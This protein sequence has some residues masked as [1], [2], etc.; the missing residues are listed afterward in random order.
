MKRRFPSRSRLCR[1][2]TLPILLILLHPI[3][4]HAQFGMNKLQ[5]GHHSW[6]HVSTRHFDLY[7]SEN[8]AVVGQY[9]AGHVEALYDSVSRILGFPLK[10]KV[11][12]ILYATPSEFQQTNII[13]YLLP[14][15]V[16]GFTEIFRNRVVIPF[17][18]SYADL[19]HVLEHEMTHAFMFDRQNT[20]GS[21]FSSASQQVPLWFGEGLAEFTS[22]GW[23]LG[24]EFYMLDAVLFGYVGNPA[25]E[26]LPGFLAYKGG[27]LFWYYLSQTFG[28]SFVRDWIAEMNK[29]SDPGKSFESLSHVSLREVGDIWLREI[30]SIY[31]PELRGRRYGKAV[32]RQLT[33]H[34][35]DG[36]NLN[37][38]PVLSPDGTK[39]AFFS[40]REPDL[41]IHV[42][43]VEKEKVS[44]SLSSA[45]RKRG[46]L[47]FYPYQSRLTWSPDGKRLAFVSKTG[48]R[49]VISMINSKNGRSAGTISPPGIQS[50]LSPDWSPDGERIV[51][52]GIKDGMSDIFV[53]DIGKKALTRLTEDIAVDQNPVYSPSGEW[54]AFESD[55]GKPGMTYDPK[56][57]FAALPE[58]GSFRDVYR[59]SSAGGSPIR[60]AGGPFDEKM[61]AYGPSDTE[62]VFVSNR[63]GINNMYIA[64]LSGGEW[65][66]EP[67]TNLTSTC[68]TPS[69]SRKGDKI[70][71][72]LFENRGW[73]IFLMR[74]PKDHIVRDSIPTTRFVRKQEHP[75][76]R[77]FEPLPVANL[78]S[79]IREKVRADSSRKAERAAKADKQAKADRVGNGAKPENGPSFP[80]GNAKDT[81]GGTP[82]YAGGNGARDT[83]KAR[84]YD[85]TRTDT[86]GMYVSRPDSLRMDS[87][88]A[89]SLRDYPGRTFVERPDT[90][91]IDLGGD[92]PRLGAYPVNEYKP[93]WGL[94]V[95]AADLGYNTF[96]R[97]VSGQTYL[98][99]S[100]LLGNHRINF[101]LSSGGASLRSTNIL[102]D[103]ELLPYRTDFSFL[104]FNFG[105]YFPVTGGYFYFDREYGG[106]VT[107]S[108]PLSIFTRFETNVNAFATSRRLY[109]A[110][111]GNPAPDS[112]FTPEDLA[113]VQPSLAWVNDNSEF[114]IVGP[115]LGRRMRAAISYVP[116]VLNDSISFVQVDGDIRQYW[117]FSKRYSIAA[118]ITAGA[119]TPAGGYSD[120]VVY[121]AGGD[122]LIP[123][124]GRTKPGNGP[125]TL[126]EAV[127]SQLAVPVRGFRFYEFRGDRKFIGNLEFRF[128][129]VETFRVVWPLPI[130]M[131]YLMGTLFLDYG[132]AWQSPPSGNELR[133]AMD[134]LGMGYGYGFRLNLGIFVLRYTRAHTVEGIGP[135]E[136]EFRSY[137][138]LGGEF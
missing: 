95:A 87:L 27:Q 13:P 48:E 57:P 70:A 90:G 130:T 106:G 98:T 53:W 36:S 32:A 67:I 109:D 56:R 131:R 119:S 135:G 89:D 21:K 19:H 40:D 124:V 34:T 2:L 44:R 1:I 69:W 7:F 23:D 99:V 8:E 72:A 117:L 20:L 51:F 104:A 50:I 108:Y 132:G 45:G 128:P 137:W 68:F 71:F 81:T 100:D 93:K 58:L 49:D 12:I 123:F 76:T 15:G 3:A 59:I 96:S 16:G 125:Q 64:T 52:N 35:G 83:S 129:F 133:A 84:A 54:I 73:D 114:G 24:S 122:D 74:D 82:S 55:R 30:R 77:F 28:P 10:T 113:F 116:P 110:L 120:P 47:S 38:Q 14:E 101:L 63:S 37:M 121:L 33:D 102:V 29:G 107:A 78:S 25:E 134:Q 112:V 41:G 17:E 18:G 42:I 92:R 4:G 94:E 97:G 22:L 80:G 46:H 103:Y 91:T 138:S 62:L 65:R 127:F 75:E 43:D 39:I 115:V 31:W 9:A 6:Y 136:G 5:Y 88:R 66:T 60:V 126:P 11:P 118:R 26:G 79:Y 61:P 85:T 105:N 86:A 111:R